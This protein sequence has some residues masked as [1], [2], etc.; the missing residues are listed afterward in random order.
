MIGLFHI[1]YGGARL[2]RLTLLLALLLL[3]VM[4]FA[5][6][7]ADRVPEDAVLYIGWQGSQAM[8]PA[9]AQ[10]HLKAILDASNL[11]ALFS[12]FAPRLIAHLGK[13]NPQ[14]V[15]ISRMVIALGTPLW[16][17]PSAL[18]V[19]PTDYKAPGAPRPH[20]AILCQAGADTDALLGQLTPLVALAQ[21]APFPIKAFK[22]GDLVVVS[23]GF[24]KEAD[25]VAGPGGPKALT[26]N[27]RYQQALAQVQKDPVAILYLD[28]EAAI[29]QTTQAIALGGAREAGEW[30][31]LRDALGLSGIHQAILTGGFDGRDWSN[32]GFIAAP[33]PRKG[34]ASMLQSKP[35]SQ[36]AM[37]L[38]P[39]NAIAAGVERLDL[40]TLFDMVRSVTAMGG[41]RAVANFDAGLAQASQKVGFDIKKDLIDAFSDEWVYY[42]EPGADASSPMDF[43]LINRLTKPAQ[44]ERS[45]NQIEKIAQQA[46][47]QNPQAAIHLSQDTVGQITT[48]TIGLPQLSITWTISDGKLLVANS[49]Q[50][51]SRAIGDDGKGKSI[52]DNADFIAL[53]KQIGGD[54]AMSFSFADLPRTAA[55]QYPG[56][57]Q[58]VQ[59]GLALAQQ[60]GIAPPPDLLPPMDAVAKELAPAASFT[61]VDAAGWHMHDHSPFPGS[62]VLS[63]N[64]NNLTVIGATALGISIILPALNGAKERANRVKCASNLRQIGQ[65]FLLYANDHKKYPPDLGTLVKEDMNIE[66]FICPS[67]DNEIP[68]AVRKATADEQ[69][70]WVNEHADY[71]YIG[72]NAKDGGDPDAIMV[73][74]KPENHDRQGINILFND[75]HVDW[76]PLN[77]AIDLIKKQK[78]DA[79][80]LK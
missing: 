9:Y 13:D 39:Q 12:D 30:I 63:P 31:K 8:P 53:R 56:I 16:Q 28:V 54:Q 77:A 1:V 41:D 44:A 79:P 25:A 73:Y 10:S 5:Q 64:G 46:I 15:P 72:A 71:Y 69:A 19:G 11:G 47:A 7:L 38:I 49:S 66:V 80:G 24:D 34:L 20:V 42:C 26:A 17:H 48:H 21:G 67:G 35:I 14:V 52:L 29:A 37:K 61:W 50:I 45:L 22:S 74:E 76:Y 32:Q 18:Y 43:V 40:R 55:I 59:L 68:D 62:S 33:A 58:A 27:P 4:A 78:P 65:G 6:P 57:L 75:G 60:Q 3:P 70:K 23:L 2:N 36:E 51:L